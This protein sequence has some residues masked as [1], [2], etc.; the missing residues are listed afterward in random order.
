MYDRGMSPADSDSFQETLHRARE[1]LLNARNERGHWEGELS[2][3]A[4]STATAVF[5]IHLALRAADG[6]PSSAGVPWVDPCRS[7]VHQGLSWLC[8]N[9]NADGGWG[10]TVR[11]FSNIS[12]TAL[13]WAVLGAGAANPEPSV[14]SQAVARAESWLVHHAGGIDRARLSAAIIARYGADKTFSVPILTMCALAGSLGAGRGAWAT[15]PQLPFE[16]AAFP[17]RWLKWLRLPVVSYA[18][19]ALI[20]IGLVRHRKRP[21][22][23]NLAARLARIVAHRRA[24]RLLTRIQPASGGFLEATPLTSFVLMSLIGAGESLDHPVVRRGIGFLIDSGRPDGSWP[25]DTHLATWV[26]TLAMNA[27]ATNPAC[28]RLMDARDRQRVR[29]WLLDQQYRTE[30]PYTLADPG[31]WAWTNLSGGVPDADDTP[32]ALLALHHLSAQPCDFMVSV[33]SASAYAEPRLRANDTYAASGASAKADPI[34]AMS[35]ESTATPIHAAAVSGVRWL[36]DLQ[37]RDGGIP[38]FC[39]GWGKLP[40]DRSSADLTAHALRAW[41]IWS[42]RLPSAMR[43][44]LAA[45]AIPR[46]VAFLCKSQNSDGSWLP[47][48]FGNQH[49]RDDQNPTYGTSRVLRAADALWRCGAASASWG[50]AWD[51]AVG[52]G[53]GWLLDAQGADGGWGGG[54]ADSPASIEE[55]ALAVE[56]LASLRPHL[57]RFA[58]HVRLDAHRS[59]G[60]APDTVLTDAIRAGTA[61]LVEHTRGGTLFE[62]T[63]I[64]FYF[65]K[66]W[67]FEK[68]YPLIFTVAALEAIGATRPEH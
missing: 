32:G 61:W 21:P 63:P 13:C 26:T 45:N 65:A 19:P 17:Q 55:T 31:G 49:V 20:A 66:L 42:E 24:L 16:L 62:P 40:F 12:T 27:I 51:K 6:R 28:E 48:W 50:A 2:S 23:V 59:T 7:L 68:L 8:A 39:R 37:N 1:A 64:G 34:V 11:S 54:A 18:L 30:H 38:T 14:V 36:M 56:S 47:L 33:G 10:D 41:S 58:D 29:D 46:A 53:V 4:L 9:Q 5:A 22:R 35:P 44:Q 25:I 3:S 57:G 67:Y 43:K 52:A 15:V 60:R